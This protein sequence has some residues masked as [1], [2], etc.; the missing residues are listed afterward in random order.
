MAIADNRSVLMSPRASAS[1]AVA[2][3][4]EGFGRCGQ[5]NAFASAVNTMRSAPKP[6]PYN[7]PRNI[8]PAGTYALSASLRLLGLALLKS[9]HPIPISAKATERE[10]GGD[11]CQW[12][13]VRYGGT[14]LEEKKH[15]HGH[16]QKHHTSHSPH[17]MTTRTTKGSSVKIIMLCK[18]VPTTSPPPSTGIAMRRPAM[19]S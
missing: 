3:P 12:K 16:W 18:A 5:N 10:R 11:G 15:G 2:A 4:L 7:P 14:A 13:E 1:D 8:I 9:K 6:I 19:T 17:S